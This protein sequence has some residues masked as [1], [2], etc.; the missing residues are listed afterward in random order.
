[1]RETLTFY[2]PWLLS[3]ITIYMTILAGNKTR[4]A[5]AIGL[6]NQALWLVWIFAAQAWG[7]LPM[8]IALWIVYSRNHLKWMRAAS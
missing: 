6:V 5:W 3:A 4:W 8:N 7:L 2:M 1:M